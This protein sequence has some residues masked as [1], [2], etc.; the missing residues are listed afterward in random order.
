MTPSGS[1]QSTQLP[2]AVCSVISKFIAEVD[3]VCRLYFDNPKARDDAMYNLQMDWQQKL[4]DAFGID[5]I[6]VLA[7]YSDLYHAGTD[8]RAWSAK[9]V[10]GSNSEFWRTQTEAIAIW[11]SGRSAA[12]DKLRSYCK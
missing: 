9:I 12:L 1:A 7:D 11:Q 8:Y 3:E 2:G 5:P 6:L 4:G 10:W